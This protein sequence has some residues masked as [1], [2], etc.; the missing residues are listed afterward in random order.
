MIDTRSIDYAA[1]REAGIREARCALRLS[2]TAGPDHLP[3]ISNMSA[4]ALSVMCRANG[5]LALGL[6]G[7]LTVRDLLPDVLDDEESESDD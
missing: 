3:I 2:L 4:F 6:L 5:P 7:H 1:G